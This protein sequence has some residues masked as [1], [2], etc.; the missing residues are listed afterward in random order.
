MNKINQIQKQFIEAKDF[1]ELWDILHEALKPYGITS[2][3]YGFGHSHKAVDINGIMESIWC[4]TS[5][6]EEYCQYYEH[7]YYIDDDLSSIH[8]LTETTPFLWH[9]FSAWGNPT[10]RQKRFM[11]ESWDFNMGVGV[12]LPFRF[13]NTMGKGGFG[14]A[15]GQMSPDEFD[16]M[17][18]KHN[19][20]IQT[21]INSFKDR[22]MRDCNFIFQ[23]SPRELEVLTFLAQGLSPS[24]ISAQLGNS[25]ST[26]GHQTRNARNKLQAVSNE[27]AV[28]KALVFSL[29]TP[30]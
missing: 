27:H 24:E 17:W 2:I 7:K 4:R 14:L 13:D 16:R 26:V 28:A 19:G 12:S 1:D 23:L 9:D 8:C 25:S 11:H 15:A 6:P 21:I 29:I 5:H 10:L 22:A 30:Q 20:P 18:D 3:F